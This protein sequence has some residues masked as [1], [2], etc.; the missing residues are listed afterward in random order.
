MSKFNSADRFLPA[1]NCATCGKQVITTDSLH[2]QVDQ[3]TVTASFYCE[4][5]RNLDAVIETLQKN[6]Y[7]LLEHL[8]PHDFWYALSPDEKRMAWGAVLDLIAR[9]AVPLRLTLSQFSDTQY[10]SLQ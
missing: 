1:I 5:Q 10:F 6:C 9:H 3:L 8:F 7:Y 2:I 4:V